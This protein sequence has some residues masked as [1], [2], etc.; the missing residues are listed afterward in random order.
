MG[1]GEK[2]RRQRESGRIIT[3]SH[4]FCQVLLLCPPGNVN[5]RRAR[6]AAAARLKRRQY[7]GQGRGPL[8]AGLVGEKLQDG[9]RAS[10]VN[11]RRRWKGQR[12]ARAVKHE[13]IHRLEMA[14]R[15]RQPR[16]WIVGQI[17]R[18]KKA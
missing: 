8:H 14:Q 9:R 13:G 12:V 1:W 11:G 5:G 15:Q 18:P 3:H 17:E 2:D 10:Q 16:Q 7:V 6:I 4:E